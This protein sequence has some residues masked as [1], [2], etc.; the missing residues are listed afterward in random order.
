MLD[1]W[2]WISLD[3]VADLEPGRSEAP[4]H[5]GGSEE[6]PIERDG[7]S[8]KLFGL[9][10]LVANVKRKKRETARTK[11]AMKLAKRERQGLGGEMNDRVERDDASKRLI[12][13]VER[14]HV[15]FAKLYP[16]VNSLGFGHHCGREV[17]PR[18]V[19]APIMKVL[20]DLA[21]AATDLAHRTASAHLV[22]EAIENLSI[23]GLARKLAGEM[24]RV[25]LGESVVRGLDQCASLVIHA[26]E[27][28]RISDIAVVQLADAGGKLERRVLEAFA[29]AFDR[30]NARVRICTD[31]Q[32]GAH[33]RANRR[34]SLSHRP[35]ASSR[36]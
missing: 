35:G 1:A 7:N 33:Q 28:K 21:G 8:P 18:D 27:N 3:D 23:E 32:T 12:T 17:E 10:R 15:A 4:Q 24:G 19:D 29:L 11:H 31:R 5:V 22:R 6:D 20:R 2:I 14:E 25:F 13:E 26:R 16:G 34:P 9:N 36:R 30:L